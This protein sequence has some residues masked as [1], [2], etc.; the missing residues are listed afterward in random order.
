MDAFKSIITKN[1]Q[2]TQPH[3]FLMNFNKSYLFQ[4]FGFG[5]PNGAASGSAGLPQNGRGA[6][7]AARQAAPQEGRPKPFGNGHAGKGQRSHGLL[8]SLGLTCP[9]GNSFH[10]FHF[11]VT[12]NYTSWRGTKL[13]TSECY[14]AKISVWWE[15]EVWKIFQSRC[16]LPLR[17]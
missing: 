6:A 12:Q 7:R 5:S 16:T 9:S 17:I 2:N 13:Y 8:F 11:Q 4:A 1:T 3:L 14:I 15:P 10:F